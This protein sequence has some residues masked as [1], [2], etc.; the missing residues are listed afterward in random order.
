MIGSLTLPSFIL[1]FNNEN[2]DINLL[3]FSKVKIK[4]SFITKIY[5]QSK[6]KKLILEKFLMS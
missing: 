2:I 1:D 6:S 3:K 4:K 5:K